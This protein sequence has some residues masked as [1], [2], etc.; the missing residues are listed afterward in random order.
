MVARKNCPISL[1]IIHTMPADKRKWIEVLALVLLLIVALAMRLQQWNTISLPD[2]AALVNMTLHLHDTPFP[3]GNYPGYLG[4]PPLFLFACR[5]NR[6][7]LW[8]PLLMEP[9]ALTVGFFSGAPNWIVYPFLN[10]GEAYRFVAY[11][12]SGFRFLG[13][14]V[15][16]AAFLKTLLDSFDPAFLVLFFIGLLAL[17]FYQQRTGIL[18]ATYMAVYVAILGNTSCFGERMVLPLLAVVVLIIANVLFLGLPRLLHPAKRWLSFYHLVIW[19]LL[20]A[21][22]ANGILQN[23]RCFNLLSTVSTYNQAIDYRFHH[24]PFEFSMA[25]ENMTPGYSGDQGFSDLASMPANSFWGPKAMPF[26]CTGLFTNYILEYTP[27]NAPAHNRLRRYLANYA[28]FARI[29]KPRFS[30]FDDDIPYW[31][32]KPAWVKG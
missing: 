14:K 23:I 27:A 31:Y 24:I 7:S 10:I 17:I 20:A 26:L 21:Y 30:S 22:A 4:Y 16:Y 3:T 1:Y 13:R 8:K 29:H 28:A 25:R 2:E 9:A 19:T 5:R 11:H 15:A 6:K 12:Y 18:L 32:K